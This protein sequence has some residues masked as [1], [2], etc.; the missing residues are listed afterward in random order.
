M[1]NISDGIHEL[2]RIFDCLPSKYMLMNGNI[3][4]I[5]KFFVGSCCEGLN[6]DFSYIM[7]KRIERHE[8]DMIGFIKGEAIFSAEFKCTFSYDRESPIKAAK[9]ACLKIKKTLNIEKLKNTK[10]Q[11]VHF[12]N[13][14]KGDSSFSLNPKWIK[15]KYPKGNAY[16][17]SNVIEIYQKELNINFQD[18]ENFSYNFNC[19]DLGLEVLIVN[20]KDGNNQI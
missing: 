1:L 15:I 18:Y 4:K 6:K 20:V 14:S 12:I 13:H 11:I 5:L 19:S 8:I 17:T 9:D 16:P 10:K 2:Q 3:E 7:D